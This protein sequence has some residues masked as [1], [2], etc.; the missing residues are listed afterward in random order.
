MNLLYL[1]V[2]CGNRGSRYQS[3]L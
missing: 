2:Q 3:L 1:H